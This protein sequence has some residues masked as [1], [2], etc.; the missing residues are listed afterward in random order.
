MF[1]LPTSDLHTCWWMVARAWREL[2][3][4]RCLRA[5][6][7]RATNSELERARG[8]G[9]EGEGGR[10]RGREGERERESTITHSAAISACEKAGKWVRAVQLL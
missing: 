2:V 7:C 9:R 4:K 10:E 5:S 6:L 1:E 3:N 8:T